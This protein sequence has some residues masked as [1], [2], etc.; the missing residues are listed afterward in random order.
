MA[1]SNVPKIQ[2]TD[3]GVV[4]PSEADVLA[5]VQMDINA[6]FG[7]GVNPALETPQGQLATSQAA[8]IA[9]KNAEIAYIANQVDPRYA[10]GRWQDALGQLY[11]MSRKAA[12]PTVVAVTIGGAIGAIIPVGSLAQDTNGNTYALTGNV[13]ID[14]TGSV[15]AEMQNVVTGP[16]P[17]AAGTLTK[18][19]QAV[20]GWDTVT[21]AVDGII[22][23]VVESR[24]DFET[25]RKNSVALNGRGTP[26]SIYANV[27]NVLD[28]SDVYVIAN[29]L[30][31]AETVGSTAYSVAAHSVYVAAVGGLD[32]S[33]A[34][35]IWQKKDLGCNYN[36][37]TIVTVLDESGYSYPQPSYQVKFE[38]P[39]SI[40]IYFSIHILN[41]ASL[42]SNI[43]TLVQTS[44]INHFNGLDGSDRARI[45]STIYASNYYGPIS[46]V[47]PNV[48]ISQ[49]LIGNPS[50]TVTT[51]SL[52]IDQVPTISAAN[53]E[54]VL[55]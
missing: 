45:A 18:V 14:G 5:G 29:P 15:A 34:N 36:G 50:A 22:G 33:I 21:N 17:C 42:P 43:I 54:V 12:L 1:T 7:G 46:A 20:S 51:F 37:N 10:D 8:V 24:A 26:E 23:R 32:A 19:Y 38:R 35:A 44:V 13:T 55:V 2:F 27:F 41:N 6:A 40:P 30:G 48:A 28:V 4:L 16:I 39:S 3:A 53:I 11:F 49:L 9:D 31:T 25:R 52:G 47:A